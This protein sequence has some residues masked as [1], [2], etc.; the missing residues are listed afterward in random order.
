MLPMAVMIPLPVSDPF[1][2]FNSDFGEVVSAVEG[3]ISEVL[4]EPVALTLPI[5][6]TND[7][8]QKDEEY[9]VT[10]CRRNTVNTREG[11]GGRARN[12]P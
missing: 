9:F 8:P 7:V 6:L 3:T 4:V 11:G 5:S 12:L 2:I 10:Y 1:D